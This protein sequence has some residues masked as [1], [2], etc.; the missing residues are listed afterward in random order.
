MI[1]TLFD[2]FLSEN[3]Y[4]SVALGSFDGVH[5]GHQKV[6]KS[7]NYSSGKKLVISFK[8]LSNNNI[9]TVDENLLE[10]QNVVND[11]TDI[12]SIELNDRNKKISK[13]DFILFLKKLNIKNIFVGSDYRFGYKA[14]GNNDDLQEHFKVHIIEFVK[15]NNSKVSSTNIRDELLKG[16]IKC[17]NEKLNKNYYILGEVIYGK[18]IGREINF[19]TVNIKPQK[20]CPKNGVYK[21]KVLIDDQYYDS[22]TNVGV[23]PTLGENEKLIETHIFDFDKE[24]YGKLIKVEFIDYIRNEEK[25]SSINDLKI[26]IKKDISK[27]KELR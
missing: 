18:Q 24:I 11:E 13:E 9:F 7:L 27:V 1:Y 8:N 12:L 5:I 17:V 20:I 3:K 10:I 4:D 22:I 23:K 15:E 14:S 16:N 2:L 21:S 19:P 25:F 6:L 26:Q